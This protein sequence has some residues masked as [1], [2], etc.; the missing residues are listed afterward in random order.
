LGTEAAGTGA[1]NRVQSIDFAIAM[2]SH[3]E[4]GFLAQ[5]R[6][7]RNLWI[8]GLALIALMLKLVIAFNT[9]GTNDVVFFLTLRKF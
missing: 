4:I 8:V 2:S 7:C 9:V 1:V 6:R 3:E 5:A